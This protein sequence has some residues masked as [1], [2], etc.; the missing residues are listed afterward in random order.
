MFHTNIL[1]GIESNCGCLVL[2][3]YTNYIVGYLLELMCK[4]YNFN[5]PVLC[6][7]GSF[8]NVTENTCQYCPLS[9]Y[10]DEFGQTSCKACPKGKFTRRRET[11]SIDECLSKLILEGI[12]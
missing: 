12:L 6:T 7:P 11:T 4:L 2:L 9:Q 3:D 8:H 5:F 10:Q 1:N